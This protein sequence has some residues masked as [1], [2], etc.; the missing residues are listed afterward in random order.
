M[1]PH[2]C[3]NFGLTR[4]WSRLAD[5]RGSSRPSGRSIPKG[6]GGS[7]M[8]LAPDGP[9]PTQITIREA[10]TKIRQWY[11]ANAARFIESPPE[12]VE[13]AGITIVRDF[14]AHAKACLDLVENLPEEKE[15]SGIEIRAVLAEVI[16]G[17]LEW[18]Y[19]QSD[20]AYKMAAYAHAG[21]PGRV[22]GDAGASR[23]GSV[24]PGVSGAMVRDCR[25]R[26]GAGAGGRGGPW[27]GGS[28]RDRGYGPGGGVGGGGAGGTRR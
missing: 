1:T 13:V 5:A 18:A 8:G 22:L 23:C 3:S 25:R 2:G 4:G 9:E 19:H 15:L 7:A 26:P 6:E 14:G 21:A 20:G 27:G 11:Q 12:E 17:K 24:S 16:A 10:Y 28:G